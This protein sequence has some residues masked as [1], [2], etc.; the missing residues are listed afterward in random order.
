VE[1]GWVDAGKAER[2]LEKLEGGI[3]LKEGWPRYE[4][5]LTRSGALVVRFTSLNPDNIEREA[6][7]LREMGLVEGVHFSVKMPEGDGEGYVSIHRKGLE[8][9][10]WLSVYGSDKQRRLAAKFVEYILRRA[11]E[12]GEEVYEKAREIVKEGKARGYLTLKGFEKEIEVDG[13]RHK[14]K[15]IDGSAEFGKSQS[16]KKLLRLRITAEVDRV[17]REYTITYSRYGADNVAR[18]SATARADAPGG[19]E[20]DAERFSALIKALT[21]KE[22][23]ILKRGDG[24]VDVICGRKHLDGFK[25]CA[26]LADAIE[27]WLE[28]TSQ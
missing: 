9:A 25:R 11:E 2:W 3:T 5:G 22:P 18:G 28:E 21:G 1:N 14:V 24:R 27:S 12:V 13:K 19:R 23:W 15:V 26:E 17:R 20:A 8:H 10:A 7:R 16:G 6:Q 4:V